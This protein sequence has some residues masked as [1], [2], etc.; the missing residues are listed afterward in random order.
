MC[1][2]GRVVYS[3]LV[4]GCLSQQEQTPNIQREA[5]VNNWFYA[6]QNYE[7]KS[8]A[9]GFCLYKN[10]ETMK[11]IP[12]VKSYCSFAGKW[13]D[14]CVYNWVS[15]NLAPDN[16]ISTDELLNLCG[17]IKDC[18]FRVLDLRSHVDV[19]VQMDLCK[20]HVAQNYRA[21]VLHSMV[22][23]WK[24]QPSAKDVSY[25][26]QVPSEPSDP[27]GFYI[28]A[29]VHCDGVG[30]CEG[31]SEMEK[32]CVELGEAFASKRQK[33]PELRKRNGEIYKVP[34]GFNKNMTNDAMDPNRNK[35]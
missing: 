22:H 30:T 3:L 17:D 31:S 11:T 18:A 4:I 32:R 35:R 28:A 19:L 6:C 15:A 1:E 5:S 9:F 33:C 10:S 13:E 7:R 2:E 27:Y 14:E 29:R 16:G 26:M 34:G 24:K 20:R 12:D 23:W 25:L 8:D 21:C